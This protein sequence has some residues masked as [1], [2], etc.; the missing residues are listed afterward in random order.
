MLNASLVDIPRPFIDS[1]YTL[2]EALGVACLALEH[3]LKPHTLALVTD[4]QRRGLGLVRDASLDHQSIHN[5]VG[6]CS[7]I[8]LAHSVVLV[9]VRTQSP[10]NPSDNELLRHVSTVAANAGLHL[11][12]WVVVG[13]G[14]LYCPR[15]IADMP[16]PWATSPA[17]L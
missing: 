2:A 8:P 12:D 17:C 11:L 13:R 6:A 1:I 4:Q 7:H 3:P 5:I 14:G 16:D 9:S 10:I 15:S